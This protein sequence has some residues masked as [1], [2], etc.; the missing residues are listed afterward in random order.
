MNSRITVRDTALHPAEIPRPS[1]LRRLLASLRDEYLTVLCYHRIGEH[2]REGFHGFRPNFSASPERFAWQMRLVKAFFTPVSLQDIVLWQKEGRRLPR[3][4]ALVTFDDGYKD[5][6]DVAWPIMR[7]LGIPGVVFVATGHVGTQKPFL[8]DFA[9]YCLEKATAGRIFVPLLGEKDLSVPSERRAATSAWVEASKR[10]PARE[11]W[12]AAAILASALGVAPPPNAFAKLYLSWDEI[13]ELDRQGL[14]FGGHTRTHPILTR[15][16]AT[17]AQ[18]EIAECQN[19]LTAELGRPALG[20][21]YPNGSTQDYSEEH[22]EAARWAGFS[23]AFSLEPGPASFREIR[24]RP[25]AVRRLYVGAKD[26]TPRFLA[27]LAGAARL[28]SA[29]A[30]QRAAER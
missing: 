9:A 20:F 21:A 1:D 12:R 27:K 8:W 17:E 29:W 22:G 7:D 23:I 15:L 10:L 30:N 13:R 14:E 11:R 19:R 6:G 25:M 26:N 24:E 28:A 4:P 2:A 16:P 18:A 5:N 3:R